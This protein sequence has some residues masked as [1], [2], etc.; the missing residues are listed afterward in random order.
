LIGVKAF[1][2]CAL[3][4]S[5]DRLKG[6]AMSAI[7]PAR[8]GAV[9][10]LLLGGMHALWSALVALGLA[11]PLIDFVFWMHF[12]K[13]VFVIEAFDVTRALILVAVTSAI[14]FAIGF[15][16]ALLWN[17]IHNRGA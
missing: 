9:L 6:F 13:P 3:V 5:S 8:T 4:A 16:L 11:Q 2:R 14:G 12:I 15:V 1:C 17:S 7:N 10:A